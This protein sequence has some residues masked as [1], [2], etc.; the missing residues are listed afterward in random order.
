MEIKTAVAQALG[1]STEHRAK[2]LNEMGM[3][4]GGGR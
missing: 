1:L 3:R 2:L 4:K